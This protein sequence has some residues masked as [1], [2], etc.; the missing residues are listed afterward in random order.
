M[1][2][3]SFS[4]TPQGALSNSVLFK[5]GRSHHQSQ[6]PHA[7]QFTKS[8][9]GHSDLKV[10]IVEDERIVAENLRM[11][12]EDEKID[13]TGVVASG[14]EAVRIAELTSP[15]VVLMDI[16]IQGQLDGIQAAILIQNILPTRPRILF[17]SAHA[18]E[19]F[20]HLHVLT[21]G[22]FGYLTKPYTPEDLMAAIDALIDD[23]S[24]S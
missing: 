21:P 15:D 11:V 20:P 22:T 1:K 12:L 16:R 24:R 10:I 9:S 2:P 19:S 8:G 5:P 4:A 3:C 7:G 17:I 23:S 13:V 14:E 6:D 18:K